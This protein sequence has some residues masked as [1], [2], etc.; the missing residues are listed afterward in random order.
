[1]EC[2][3]AIAILTVLMVKNVSGLEYLSHCLKK[4]NYGSKLSLG[5]KISAPADGYQTLAEPVKEFLITY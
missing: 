5:A 4:A 1:M 2:M 3:Y